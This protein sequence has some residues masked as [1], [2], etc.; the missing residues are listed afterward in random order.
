MAERTT[1]AIAL[2]LV[3][4]LTP[5]AL[6]PI[7]SYDFFWHLATGRWIVEHHALP[8]TDPFTVASDRMP[9]INGEWLFEVALYAIG[10]LRAAALLRAFLLALMFAAAF[11]FGARDG[12]PPAAAMLAAIAFCGA[13]ARLDLRPSTVAAF[14]LV[15]AIICA[16][17]KSRLADVAFILIAVVWIN[18]HPSA[19][20]IPLV[21]LLLRPILTLPAV[22]ALLVNPFGWR[23]IAAP[24]ELTAFARS[25]AFVNAEW[26]P[27]SPMLFPLL[28]VCLILGVTFF[29]AER[30]AVPRFILFVVLGYLAVAHVRNQGLF[31]AAFPLLIAPMRS[32]KPAIA[33]SVAAVM[34]VAMLFIGD[35]SSGVA[36]HRFPA[37]SARRLRETGLRGNVYNPDQFGGYLIWA[38]Y[39]ERRALTDGRNEL[40]RT[41]IPEYARARNDSRAW[42]ALLQ[43]YRIDLAVD[44]Y[45]G[46]IDTVDAATKQHRPMPASLAYW[47]RNEWA[48]IGYDDVSMVFARRAAFPG[49]VLDRWEWK[50]ATPD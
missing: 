27:S 44:E 29:L 19:L 18:V 6:A 14:L 48:L 32:L 12:D 47:P 1:I 41:Y 34:V 33:W 28:Y 13:W 8:L 10:G 30:K 42:R 16:T 21:A 40:Y 5:A 25:G 45:R 22:L 15:L 7:R 46:R 38:F 4:L 26:L 11:F 2:A 3:V 17:R 9:W 31:F 37:A 43:K 36:P 50:G 20:I 39:P 49:G 35:H 24:L 23:A